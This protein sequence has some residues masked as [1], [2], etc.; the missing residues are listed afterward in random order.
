MVLDLVWNLAFV[1]V[2]AGV[3]FSTLSENPSTPLRLWLCGYA[4][5][6]VIH[7]AFVCFEYWR[8]TRRDFY[9]PELGVAFSQTWNRYVMLRM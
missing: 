8:R 4:F 9:G 1:L 2:T 6:C 3:L 5:E 7:M